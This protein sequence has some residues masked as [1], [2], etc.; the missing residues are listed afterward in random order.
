M[1]LEHHVDGQ[2]VVQQQTTQITFKRQG[3]KILCNNNHSSTMAVAICYCCK[4]N[5]QNME[6][7]HTDNNAQLHSER[8]YTL[9]IIRL[10]QC[11]T[12]PA[13]E[14][15]RPRS[16]EIAGIIIIWFADRSYIQSAIFSAHIGLKLHMKC[17]RYA[18]QPDVF[19]QC[20][21]RFTFCAKFNASNKTSH[22]FSSFSE[23]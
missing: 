6:C 17:S 21:P 16:H 14:P 11:Q 23:E 10:S 8:V 4:L 3:D 2:M 12:F 1:I 7:C 22:S 20:Q 5:R 9:N 13:L 19:I 15:N 18:N